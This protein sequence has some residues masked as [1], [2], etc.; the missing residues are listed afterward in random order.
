VRR[1]KILAT[2]G[3]ASSDAATL[4]RLIGAGVDGLRLNFSHGSSEEHRAVLDR[5]H[6]LTDRR[7][8]AVAIVADLQGPKVRIGDLRPS[9]VRL[10][11]GRGV[12]LDRRTEP[13]DARRIPVQLARLGGAARVGDPILLGDGAVEL[14]VE[15]VGDDE[16]GARVL[17]GGPITSHAGLFLPRARLRTSVLGPK[18]RSDL[19]LAVAGGVDFVALSFVQGP[20][21]VQSGRRALVRMERGGSVG[22]IAKI[23]RAPALAAIDE[24]LPLADGIMVARGDLGIEVPL[25]RLAVE[26]KRLVARANA[27]G[28]F[29]IV[30]TQM[31]LSMVD[32]PR[33][34]RAEATDVANAVLD[35]ADAVM[36][37]EESAVGHYPV[38]AVTWLDRICR[39]TEDA[40]ARGEVR[41]PSPPAP[42]ASPE[43]SVARAAVDLARHTSAA[44][45]VTP[46]HSG[47]TAALISAFRP[48]VP[49][50]ALTSQPPTR[51]KLALVWGVRARGVPAHLS[52]GDLRR[53]AGTIA[54]SIL[55]PDAKFRLVLTAGYPVEGRPTNLVTVLEEGLGSAVETG[56]RR[57]ARRP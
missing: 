16:L 31:L 19:E 42:T 22:I 30:A 7:A 29:A 21:D 34:T 24:I 9:P 47:R 14:I 17:H 32:A 33:P 46:T 51:R 27:A 4:R 1:T 54:R 2:V 15:R 25:E 18:D 26:Q 5:I 50:V 35:G 11:E 45:I 44:A 41:G 38:E 36:L 43:G 37:S 13:G 52:L 3:P 48:A 12:T 39:T 57:A 6:R 23:E 8:D 49:I 10:I 53:R 20:A 40:M 56:R 55:R 28:K